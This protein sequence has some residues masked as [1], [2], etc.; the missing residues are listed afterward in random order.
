MIKN[1]FFL[2]SEFQYLETDSTYPSE[3]LFYKHVVITS[4][5]E[6]Q[7]S[8]PIL[9][10][11]KLILKDFG[12]SNI[13]LYN[14]S[15]QLVK[16]MNTNQPAVE[17]SEIFSKSQASGIYFLKVQVNNEMYTFKILR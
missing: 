1:C 11:E 14:V 10:N 2:H 13:Y 3:L 16:S 6:V 9:T 7:N 12:F 8:T 17:L 4:K 5:E 15:G